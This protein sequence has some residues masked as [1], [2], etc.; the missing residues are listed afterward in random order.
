MR[1]FWTMPVH[2]QAF[3][4]GRCSKCNTYNEMLEFDYG[5]MVYRDLDKKMDDVNHPIQNIECKRCGTR[6]LP[7]QLVTRELLSKE[8]VVRV[9]IQYGNG[10]SE[11]ESA[12]MME[13]HNKRFEIF[14]SKEQEF[15]AAYTNFAIENWR[16]VVNELTRSEI[17]RAY[18]ALGLQAELKTD[19]HARKD[20]LNRIKTNDLKVRFWREANQEFIFDEI[21]E[22]GAMGWAPELTAK[23]FGINRSRFAF[24]HFPISEASEP[25]R[26]TA[27]GSL[28]RK[29]KGDN[30]FL[31]HQISRLSDDVAKANRRVS[32]IFHKNEK[33]K[34]EHAETQRKLSE[35]YATIRN[36]DNEIVV[37]RDPRDIS[38]IRELKSFVGDLL[39]ELRGFRSKIEDIP[40]KSDMIEI[41]EVPLAEEQEL[42]LSRLAGKIVA[43][44]GGERAEHAQRSYP[45]TI[46]T[47]NGWKQDVSFYAVLKQ[48][49]FIVILTRHVSHAS[50]W[51]SKAYA[52][53]NE[54]PVTYCSETNMRRIL[55][56][57]ADQMKVDHHPK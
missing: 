28:F 17:G 54:I 19:Q 4:C 24:M 12:G 41:T 1:D 23:V 43:V 38:R 2:M 8:E 14:E 39:E 5:V 13:G 30:A 42:D 45:C 11:E 26:T 46:L 36:S 35:A 50:M 27:I 55:E 44:I 47:H 7:E 16:D 49:D 9:T 33:L 22:I 10:I 56:S 21:L 34:H 51:E 53:E 15:W 3:F 52:I 6:Y 57:I 20:V 31:L 29:D 25:Q 18:S 40:Q 37:N 48:A 32:N